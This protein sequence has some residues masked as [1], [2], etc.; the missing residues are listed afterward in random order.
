MNNLTKDILGDLVGTILGET[1]QRET[2]KE[3]VEMFLKESR[4]EQ[5][6]FVRAIIDDYNYYSEKDK[7]MLTSQELFDIT[8]DIVTELK[9]RYGR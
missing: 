5:I 8:S 1:Y 7:I 4:K 2:E 3:N 6:E 9:N